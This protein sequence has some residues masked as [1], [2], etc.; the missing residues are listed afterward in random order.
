VARN[1]N[2]LVAA[3]TPT[4]KRFWLPQAYLSGWGLESAAAC[5]Y[6]E[7][8]R[9]KRVYVDVASN[10]ILADVYNHRVMKWAP[11]ATEGEVVAGGNI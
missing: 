1:A 9:G 5:R 11:C 8:E 6:R 10:Y 4:Q 7:M 3:T 2:A